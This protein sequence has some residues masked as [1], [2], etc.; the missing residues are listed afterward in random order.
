MIGVADSASAPAARLEIAQDRRK[1]PARRSKHFRGIDDRAAAERHDDLGL[2]GRAEARALFGQE[3]RIGIGRDVAD[4]HDRLAG[5]TPQTLGERRERGVRIGDERI[6][7]AADKL[8]QFGERVDPERDRDRVAIPPHQ[9][10]PGTEY[11]SLP[12]AKFKNS[13]RTIGNGNELH[14]AAHVPR[15]RGPSRIHLCRQGARHWAADRHA[16]RVYLATAG[17]CQFSISKSTRPS[18]PFG[19]RTFRMKAIVRAR[20]TTSESPYLPALIQLGPYIA[21]GTLVSYAQG[22]P[23]VDA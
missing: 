9:P 17:H 13:M 7:L 3:P 23:C 14:M 18:Q 11:R 21:S 4:G 5:R 22:D 15:G 2:V 19:G 6:G 1:A 10:L 12:I 8:R 20:S 16:G